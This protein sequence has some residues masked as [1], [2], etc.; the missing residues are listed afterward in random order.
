MN[1]IWSPLAKTDFWRNIEYLEQEWS[2]KEVISFIEQVE[3]HID[4]IRH[5]NVYFVKTKYKNVFKLVIVRQIT[6]FYRV[7]QGNVELLRF[8]NNYQDLNKFKLK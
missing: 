2:P 1:I 8:W 4:L 5:N 3:H 7:S 6:L